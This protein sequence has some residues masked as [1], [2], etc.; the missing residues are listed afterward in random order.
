MG[1]FNKL[2]YL[3][4]GISI[5]IVLGFALFLDTTKT[6]LIGT[7][8]AFCVVPAPGQ[9]C[10]PFTGICTP[11]CLIDSGDVKDVGKIAG[12]LVGKTF[13]ETVDVLDKI[14]VNGGNAC[15][16]IIALGPGGFGVDQMK[17]L[18]SKY[19]CSNIPDSWPD[20]F[21]NR[22][23]SSYTSAGRDSCQKTSN[24]KCF[25]YSGGANSSP[26]CVDN[27]GNMNDNALCRDGG[28][29]YKGEE[30]SSGNYCSSSDPA[31]TCA[32]NQI[33]NVVRYSCDASCP[34]DSSKGGESSNKSL[35]C[36]GSDKCCFYYS[37]Y[38]PAATKAPA[39]D[40]CGSG[41]SC[42]HADSCT[43]QIYG[44]LTPNCK[45][46]GSN[47]RCCKN[48]SDGGGSGSS[49]PAEPGVGYCAGPNRENPQAVGGATC[50]INNAPYDS[51]SQ[52]CIQ[53][54]GGSLGNFFKCSA[55][56]TP[57]GICASHGGPDTIF[58][59]PN[60]FWGPTCDG[61]MIGDTDPKT[62]KEGRKYADRYKCAEY[63]TYEDVPVPS[64]DEVCNE[65]PWIDTINKKPSTCKEPNSGGQIDCSQF[66]DRECTLDFESTSEYSCVKK[67]FK[68][69]DIQKKE[70]ISTGACRGIAGQGQICGEDIQCNGYPEAICVDPA[71]TG[72]KTCQWKSGTG[73]TPTPGAST[74]CNT[75]GQ[76][77]TGC[78]C[79]TL[80]G[81]CLTSHNCSPAAD[82]STK[83]YCVPFGTGERWCINS[84]TSIP[85]LQ[86]ASATKYTTP[87]P[88]PTISVR[89]PNDGNHLCVPSNYCQAGYG[90]KND[91]TADSACASWNPD[92][93]KCYFKGATALS[94]C[95]TPTATPTR[96][97]SLVTATPK[98]TPPGCPVDNGDGRVNSC[99][100]SC[101]GSYP[102]AKPDGNK[103]CA[104]AYGT[105]RGACCTSN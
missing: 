86:C 58:S 33:G 39:S 81:G 23:C 5:I 62:A 37:N 26:S 24:G 83:S 14:S 11:G 82:D 52:Y 47:M 44:T 104:N 89:C 27:T 42:T 100:K 38:T 90:P 46:N 56:S 91:A 95:T 76:L 57:T 18:L 63:N 31:I 93:P 17:L 73:P 12:K 32:G 8:E 77:G 22:D 4:F 68:W 9:L 55:A 2:R 71:N 70:I 13:N 53:K 64:S 16:V 75:P 29:C 85:P 103:D 101:T 65:Y 21:K 54:Y 67:G 98:P 105:I 7:V 72:F 45:A 88:T 94:S 102:N 66:T 25:W 41:Y 49:L 84:Q 28:H 1:L 61:K 97:P 51:E 50:G 43:S 74:R 30:C 3:T 15:N 87:T 34:T 69:C 20:V 78:E 10:V 48:V 36:S 60:G 96:N 99:Q 6:P 80:G 40:D 35:T 19:G 79:G 92:T 59:K